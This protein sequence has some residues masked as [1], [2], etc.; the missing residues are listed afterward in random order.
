MIPV[1]MINGFLDSGKSMFIQYTISQPYFQTKGT[2]LVIVCEEGEVEY[3]SELLKKSNAVMEL[4][5]DEEDFTPQNLISL[6]KKHRPVRVLI[7][8]NGMWNSK[9]VKF[10]WHWKLEQQITLIDGS[11]F[12]SYFT[13]M[14]SL[15]AEHIRKSE[16]IMVNRCDNV[17][18]NIPSYKRNIKAI[19]QNAEI[20]FED[21]NGEVNATLEE[22]LPY[23]VSA[24]T[25]ELNDMA[26]GIWYIDVLDNAPRYEGKTVSYVA[27]VLKPKEFPKGYFVPGR[28]AMTCCA[29]DMAFLGYAC[30]YDK[31]DD[32]KEQDWIRVTAKVSLE[33]FEDYGKEG[34]VLHAVS[35]EKTDKP[36]EPVISFV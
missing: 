25:I 18:E 13:N 21:K 8:F 6:E 14:K 23:D 11:T 4:I 28:M 15:I 2:T 7:E 19:N 5:E 20:I 31:T 30:K 34:P 33:Y 36:A 26:Y 1:Y 35:I 16:M 9:N 10:P 24:E 12:A 32:L 17:M 29:E 22:D 27:Q 3:D